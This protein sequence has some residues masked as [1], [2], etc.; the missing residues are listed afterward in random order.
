MPNVSN[1]L[2][3]HRRKI[4]TPE[5]TLSESWSLLV[6]VLR[7]SKWY[8]VSLNLQQWCTLWLKWII[9][10]CK[11][12]LTVINSTSKGSRSTL[13]SFLDFQGMPYKV[14]INCKSIEHTGSVKPSSSNP[15]TPAHWAAWFTKEPI[16]W[17]WF[18]W[19][20]S[21]AFLIL[22]LGLIRS[23][24]FSSPQEEKTWQ[25]QRLQSILESLCLLTHDSYQPVGKNWMIWPL[26]FRH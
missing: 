10:V 20:N 8:L 11:I 16:S 4:L 5:N 15:M 23:P 24:G 21:A 14:Q 9:Q 17:G 18:R 2:V 3:D 6:P 19:L 26:M 7:P 25:P 12:L 1:S 22:L 13:L